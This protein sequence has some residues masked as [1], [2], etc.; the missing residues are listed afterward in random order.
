M[1]SCYSFKVE[2]K[3]ESRK[4]GNCAFCDRTMFEERIIAETNKFFVIAT[5]GQITDGGY[6][7]IFPKRHVR[8]LGALRHEEMM[9]F[10]RLLLE[11]RGAIDAEYT[12]FPA[13]FE[14][15]IVGQTVKHAHFHCVPS[16]VN[17][18]TRVM[19]DFPQTLHESFYIMN[20]G[21]HCQRTEKLQPYLLW[22]SSRKY[23]LAHVW[24]DPHNVPAQ[25]FRTILAE[26]LGR[27]E[28]A[29]WRTMDPVLDK[30]LWSETVLR[31]KKYF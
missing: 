13:M 12:F 15:G 4:M 7:L 14:H 24:R 6:V 25:Y 3:K 10:I 1:L 11:V 18:T 17:L 27:P 8:C 31:L 2:I 19:N 28:R 5:L 16:G 9:N 21:I 26:A 23:P 29:N 30:L 20:E 22:S